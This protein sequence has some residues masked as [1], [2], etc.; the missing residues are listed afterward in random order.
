MREHSGANNP[1]ASLT[2]GQVSYIRIL[3]ARGSLSQKQIALL[4]GV[5]RSTI[6]HIKTGHRWS[7]Q[8]SNQSEEMENATD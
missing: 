4:F 2:P 3:L 1:H 6:G 7:S 5:S 8:S